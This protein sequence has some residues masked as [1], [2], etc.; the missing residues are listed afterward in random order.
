LPLLS[1]LDTL[2]RA[3][4]VGSTDPDFYEGMAA[5]HRQFMTAL[6]EAGPSPSTASGNRSIRTSTRRWRQLRPRAWSPGRWSASCGAA[7]GSVD[8]LLRPAQVVVAAAPKAR[9]PWR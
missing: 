3:L 2:E 8:E 7:G 9:D 6:R 1:V 4:A 5:T